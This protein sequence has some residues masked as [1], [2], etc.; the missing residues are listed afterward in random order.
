MPEYYYDTYL[1]LLNQTLAKHLPAIRRA[2]D[3]ER[4]GSRQD[5]DADLQ[6]MISR[7]F[8]IIQKEFEK[9]AIVFGLERKLNKL[10]N[11]T[12]KLSIREWKRVVRNTL[13]IDIMEDYYMGEF[14][15]SARP[16]GRR[17]QLLVRRA[18]GVQPARA[19][20]AVGERRT[21]TRTGLYAGS[22]GSLNMFSR[23]KAWPRMRASRSSSPTAAGKRFF[24]EIGEL[25]LSPLPTY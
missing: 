5:S 18:P 19:A 12:R 23:R 16:S 22:F 15:R 24:K 20:F 8:M 4:Q 2:I 7:T 21:R 25:K 9:K 10:A 13:G 1:T 11:L 17:L 3:A 14:Y 6:S